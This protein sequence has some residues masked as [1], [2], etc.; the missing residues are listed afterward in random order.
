[1][2]CDFDLNRKFSDHSQPWWEGYISRGQTRSHLK[3]G[4]HRPQIF[5]ILIDAYMV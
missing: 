3:T 4:V 5:G 1:M 2:I